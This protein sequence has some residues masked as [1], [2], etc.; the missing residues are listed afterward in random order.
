MI[1]EIEGLLLHW[2][3]QCRLNGEGGSMGSPMGTIM[4]WGGCAPR[5]TPGSRIL[6]GDGSGP[7]GVAQ[8]IAAALAEIGR[9]DARGERLMRLAGLRYGADPAPTIRMQMHLIGLTSGAR[10]TYYDH[11]HALHLRLRE[12]LTK[13]AAGRKWLTVRRGDLPQTCAKVA[14]KLRRAS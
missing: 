10:Q 4:E 1:E 5:G 9:Q 6:L 3:Q 8:E 12:V 13:R 11:V 14:S 7:D 2:G